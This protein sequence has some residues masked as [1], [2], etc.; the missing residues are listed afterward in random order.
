MPEILD[1]ADVIMVRRQAS[2]APFAEG[3]DGAHKLVRT[4]A[5]CFSVVMRRAKLAD[6]PPVRGA[7]FGCAHLLRRLGPT[8]QSTDAARSTGPR[9]RHL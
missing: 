2:F 9:P 7:S 6:C 5:G 3:T 8:E 4:R 1:R